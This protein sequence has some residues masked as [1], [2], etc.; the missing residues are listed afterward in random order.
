DQASRV[1]VTTCADNMD[2]AS[3]V[4]I[5]TPANA[6]NMAQALSRT[7]VIT[8]PDDVDNMDQASGVVIT[9][10]TDA[11]NMDQAS[12]QL[13]RGTC[14]PIR[15]A[16]GKN[17]RVW[18][19]GDSYVRRGAQRAAETTGRN[20]GLNDV[21]ICWFGWGGLRWRRLFP[22]PN[23]LRGRAAPD[24]LLIHCGG[25]DLGETTSV[26]LVTRMKEDLHQLHHWHPHMMIMFSSLCQRCQ[27]RAAANP[28]RVDKAR[29][30]V[31]S[32]M[33]T[34]VMGWMAAIVEHPPH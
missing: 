12:R 16:S 26:E 31:N 23:C 7:V 32:V 8:T 25:N 34:F 19:M 27:W 11:D 5:A 3:G 21:S 33:A 22:F 15:C 17:I 1:V 9:T 14:R 29:K 28:V 13:A 24:V 30:F 10:P 4:V 2:Q 20:L 6:D 18:I